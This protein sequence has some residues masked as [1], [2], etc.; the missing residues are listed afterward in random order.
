MESEP[1]PNALQSL[2]GSGDVEKDRKRRNTAKS[3]ISPPEGGTDRPQEIY[4]PQC[5][6]DVLKAVWPEGVWLDPC[7]GPD[8]IVGASR[9]CCGSRRAGDDGLEVA[10][11]HFTYFNPP[12]KYLK[13]W[14]YKAYSEVLKAGGNLELIG[15][16]PVRTHRLWWRKTLLDFPGVTVVYLDPLK[17]AGYQ[18]AFPA[19]LCLAYWGKRHEEFLAATEKVSKR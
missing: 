2:W 9:R 18:Q 8:S 14:L 6:V 11:P 4:T 1:R 16:F 15:L 12:Y 10:W 3:M 19:P 13:D 7:S 17:F 5:I